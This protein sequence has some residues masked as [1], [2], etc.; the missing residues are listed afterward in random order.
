MT[1]DPVEAMRQKKKPKIRH[2]LGKLQCPKCTFACEK[3][4]M[5]LPS[6]Q[7]LLVKCSVIQSLL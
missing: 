2:V 7:I 4:G 5:D 6:M 3:P 1:T